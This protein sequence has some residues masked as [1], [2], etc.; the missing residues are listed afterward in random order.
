MTVRPHGTDVKL[1]AGE[2]DIAPK[3]SS[4]ELIGYLEND[5]TLKSNEYPVRIFVPRIQL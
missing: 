1:M 4:S 5:E 3:R 2:I